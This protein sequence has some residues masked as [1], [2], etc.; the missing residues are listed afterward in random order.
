MWA[1]R[2]RFRVGRCPRCTRGQPGIAAPPHLSHQVLVRPPWLNPHGPQSPNAMAITPV[3]RAQQTPQAQSQ[4]SHGQHSSLKAADSIQALT[5]EMLA[6]VSVS[7][8]VAVQETEGLQFPATWGV[9]CLTG[10]QSM[11]EKRNCP[12]TG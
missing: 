9:C 4:P 8:M 11:R 12:Q 6:V 2:A 5:H 1:P 10:G 3:H 7:L